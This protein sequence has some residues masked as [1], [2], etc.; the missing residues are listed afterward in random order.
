MFFNLA[1]KLLDFGF[2]NYEIIKIEREECGSICVRKGVK[3]NIKVG[4]EQLEVLENIGNE[5][6]IEK[7][8]ILNESV[9][10]PIKENDVVGKIIYKVNGQVIAEG[11]ILALESSERLTFWH[12]F[13][14]NVTNFLLI[15][16]K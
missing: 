12:F 7:E 9:V 8:I 11:D 2:A 5:N 16:K 15:E 3:E 13:L 6:K 4:C 14:K 1:T 10:A